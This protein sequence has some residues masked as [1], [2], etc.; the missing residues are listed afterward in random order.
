ME[1][2]WL[3][4]A[5]VGANF[6][7]FLLS[8]IL[9]RILTLSDFGV[10]TFFSTIISLS[11]V[12]FG[13]VSSTITHKVAFWQGQ[14]KTTQGVAFARKMLRQIFLWSMLASV[15]WILADDYIAKFFQVSDLTLI[16]FFSP[17]LLFG[18]L[19]SVQFGFLK[20]RF[21]F[22][23]LGIAG[24][25]EAISKLLFALAFV[26]S[27]RSD[28]VAV[29]IPASIAISFLVLDYY[30]NKVLNAS[31]TDEQELKTYIGKTQAFPFTFFGASLLSGIAATLFLNIDVLVAKHTLSPEN[32]GAY[33]LLSLVG[34]MIFLFGSLLSTLINPI[35]SHH[36]GAKTDSRK[37]FSKLFRLTFITSFVGFIGVGLLGRW[38]VPLLFGSKAVVIVPHLN[39]F[40]LAMVA[41]TLSCALVSYRVARKQFSFAWVQVF[42]S[43]LTLAGL[44]IFH[45]TIGELSFVVFI[46][47]VGTLMLVIIWRA[48]LVNSR[49]V[50]RNLVDLLDLFSPLSVPTTDY[51][52]PTTVSK[53]ILI[54]NWRDTT[55]GFAGGA[56]SYI[57]ELA[58]RWV[59]AGHQVT[60]FSGNDGT[61]T[62]EETID[63]VQIIR[64]G[65]FYFVYVWAFFYYM[66]Q[67]R[68]KYDLIIDCQNGIP[69]FTPFFAREKVY[70]LLHHVHQE[71][72]HKF[73]SRPLALFAAF[74]EKDLMPYVYRDTKF[75][76]VSN[77]SKKE[78]EDLGLG[79]AGIEVIHPGVD[80]AMLEPG[81]KAKEPTVLY[82]GRLKA[83]KSVDMLVHAF[84]RVRKIIPTAKLVIAGGGEEAH[85]LRELVKVKKLTKAVSFKGKVSDTEK[86]SLLQQAWVFVNPSM[87]EGWGITTIEANACGVPVVASNVPGLRESVQNPHTGYLVPYGD[88]EALAGRITELLEQPK[89]REEM[90]KNAIA[91]AKN[92]DWEISS[93]K[94]LPLIL[95]V[96]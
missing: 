49:F 18:S 20:G 68:G 48:I 29:S 96:D 24:L 73:L 95:D 76:T 42:G 26:M 70:C 1:G 22:K 62:R 3:M 63:G 94:T 80:L 14:K 58:K 84:E 46:G 47:A 54:F 32:A 13:A 88:L 64:R 27:G 43:V 74:L 91:W 30:A 77:S 65:G 6:F 25:V 82:L 71:V 45:S 35:V 52:L 5:S 56:E 51:R 38:T 53:K 44:F 28:L 66:F 81:K 34:K 79:L 16:W 75:I 55:H 9:G 60:Q 31:F 7:N 83:Y 61:Q 11:A 8:A 4:V 2:A 19:A 41:F 72:F 90:S 85:N 59:L 67:F 40:G 92:F 50:L 78:M 23:A 17:A 86:L 33:A 39:T 21:S 37:A 12:L 36:D 87:L 57:H 15:L 93:Q 89:L 10:I 69:F